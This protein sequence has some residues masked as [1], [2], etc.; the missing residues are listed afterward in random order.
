MRL[1]RGR[2]CTCWPPRLWKR[3]PAP[4]A[5]RLIRRRCRTHGCVLPTVCRS[6]ERRAGAHPGWGESC[7]ARHLH[8]AF[9][10]VADGRHAAVR[11]PPAH[12]A[13]GARAGR[14]RARGGYPA[15]CRVSR[16]G[17]GAHGGAAGL[18]RA[19]RQVFHRRGRGQRSGACA[20]AA[21]RAG[22]RC[23]A[24]RARGDVIAVR[25]V[26]ATRRGGVGGEGPCRQRP[27]CVCALVDGRAKCCRAR[28]SRGQAPPRRICPGPR[29]YASAR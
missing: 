10:P 21:C 22:R 7:T 14:L 4:Q 12:P 27:R 6:P 17:C 11:P 25:V 18:S 2:A 3:E 13:A 20:G 29:Q 23:A 8:F 26:V 5:C 16:T 1:V 24:G 19:C 9:R 15:A 28:C